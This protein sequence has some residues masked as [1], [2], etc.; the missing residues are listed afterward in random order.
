VQGGLSI[1]V[2]PLISLMEDQVQQLR[3]EGL[4]ALMLNSG[5]P[6]EEARATMTQLHE[7]YAGLLYVAPER[8]FAGGFQSVMEKLK[9]RLLAVDEAHC[10]FRSAR[11][12]RPRI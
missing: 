1:V 8:F 9:P 3:D 7:G 10:H 11:R 5:M 6:A 2:S 4:P 12:S